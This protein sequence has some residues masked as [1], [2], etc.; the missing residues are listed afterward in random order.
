MKVEFL[1]SFSKDLDS[2]NSKSAKK[3]LLRVIET[4]E[5]AID[6]NNA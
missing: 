1:K 5:Q 4:L 6:L 3:S 2:V